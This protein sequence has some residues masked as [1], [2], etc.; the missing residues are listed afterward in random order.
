M[1]SVD[2]YLKYFLQI[3]S[4]NDSGW[5][6]RICGQG[7]SYP[8][9][10]GEENNLCFAFFPSYPII[11]RGIHLLLGIS[12]RASLLLLSSVCSMLLPLLFFKWLETRG[13]DKEQSYW[14]AFLL[15]AFPH[16]Y[17]FSMIYTESLFLLSGIAVLYFLEKEQWLL[18]GV[19]CFIFVLT[20]V[21]AVC[22]FLPIYLLL[23]KK[24]GMLGKKTLLGML[25]LCL[26]LLAYL[27]IFKL[28]TGDFLFFKQVSEAH[29]KGVPGNPL[30]GFYNS[31]TRGINGEYF[32][33]Y[34]LFYAIL[35]IG[36]ALRFLSTRDYL[37][38]LILVISIIL[39]PIYEGAATSQPRFI[40]TAF[41]LFMVLGGKLSKIKTSF[42]KTMVTIIVVLLH[43]A[44]FIAWNNTWPLSY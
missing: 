2:L 1:R 3:F 13:H 27:S 28:Q 42:H 43:Y 38:M 35:A 14:S 20:R 10:V 18:Y 39:L 41:P 7:Y 19:A 30:I 34:N 6:E 4:N 8:I 31:L 26:P 24:Y 25:A 37:P 21:H 5:Y 40:S 36:L 44:S 33:L 17:Y 16:A 32:L 22:W 11:G 23:C 9:R 15:M 12:P 29:W